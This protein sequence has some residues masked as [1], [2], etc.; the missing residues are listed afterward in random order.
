MKTGKVSFTS[1]QHDVSTTRLNVNNS[2]H[3]GGLFSRADPRE[4]GPALDIERGKMVFSLLVRPA[5]YSGPYRSYEQVRE[6]RTQVHVAEGTPYRARF[7]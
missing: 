6:S 5:Y 7:Q 4:G 3:L 2:W 1:G